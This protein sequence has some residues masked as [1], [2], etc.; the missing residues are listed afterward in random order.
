MREYKAGGFLCPVNQRTQERAERVIDQETSEAEQARD[1]FH[2]V[3]D[4]YCWDMMKIEGATHL[5][6]KHPKKAMSFDKSNLLVS[7]LRS[8]DIPARFRVIQCTFHNEHK[9][10][11]DDSLHA[12]VEIRLNNDWIIA[13]PAFGPHTDAF[14][15]TAPFGEQTWEAIKKEH[16]CRSL[17]RLLVYSYNYFMRFVHPDVRTIREE[18]RECQDL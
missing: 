15:S 11:T 2:H 10:R 16:T 9:D 8:V 17:P 18:L 6:T 1:L 3:R 4:G 14:K 13:D 12:P 7:L 5:L